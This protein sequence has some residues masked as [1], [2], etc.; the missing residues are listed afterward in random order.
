MISR[1]CV[2]RRCISQLRVYSLC[3]DAITWD[4]DDDDDDD[5]GKLEKHSKVCTVRIK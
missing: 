5:E 4:D 3:Y 1:L 2:Q